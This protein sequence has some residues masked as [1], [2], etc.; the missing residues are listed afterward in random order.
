VI[1]KRQQNEALITIA[2]MKNIID[3]SAETTV[4]ESEAATVAAVTASKPKIEGVE[5]PTMMPTKHSDPQPNVNGNETDAKAAAVKRKAARIAKIIQEN[6]EALNKPLSDEEKQKRKDLISLARQGLDG[7]RFSEM[8]FREI[9]DRRLWRGTHKSF[10]EFCRDEF[11]LSEQRVSQILASADELAFLK[12]KIDDALLPESERAIRELRRVKQDNKVM[13][14]LLA[15]E[16]SNG[17]RPNSTTI[18]KARLQIE[19]VKAKEDK[20]ENPKADA[21]LKAAN[22]LK[23]FIAA[24]DVDD[25]K[26]GELRELRETIATISK[27]AAKLAA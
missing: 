13:V 4:K 7:A 25:L 1:Q 16:I 27:D 9:R 10:D 17:A 8:A 5:T 23:D 22:L 21:A 6:E 11:D 24:A 3:P 12:G 18:E 14:L 19:G 26:I 20:S 15:A 2:T